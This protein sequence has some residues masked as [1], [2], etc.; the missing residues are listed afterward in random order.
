MSCEVAIDV[1][2]VKVE[3]LCL[4][5]LAQRKVLFEDIVADGEQ[6]LIK[7]ATCLSDV[8]GF[9]EFVPRLCPF[10]LYVLDKLEAL[11]HPRQVLDTH[12]YAYTPEIEALLQRF[13]LSMLRLRPAGEWKEGGGD[14]GHLQDAS[15]QHGFCSVPDVEALQTL[16]VSDDVDLKLVHYQYPGYE[17]FDVVGLAD[18]AIGFACSK[19]NEIRTAIRESPLIAALAAGNIDEFRR[20]C[21]CALDIV[22]EPPVDTQEFSI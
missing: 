8:N 1:A 18:R 10:D 11:V 6:V 5:S 7:R 9:R 22:M 12:M 21:L 13:E 3:A 16:L 17:H 4:S 19:V 14:I 15:L 20:Q 2:H